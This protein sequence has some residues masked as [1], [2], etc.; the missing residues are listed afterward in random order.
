MED[1][2]LDSFQ[3]RPFH[4]LCGPQTKHLLHQRLHTRLNLL[5]NLYRSALVQMVRA[6]QSSHGLD[7][8]ASFLENSATS[9]GSRASTVS[10]PYEQLE[11][12]IVRNW[13]RPTIIYFSSPA[14]F[15]KSTGQRN[16]QWRAG[17]TKE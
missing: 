6:D 13:D 17:R 2:A 5:K 14:L 1:L 16:G 15:L 7:D 10:Q 4:F 8:V 9:T 3:Q 12:L 11:L